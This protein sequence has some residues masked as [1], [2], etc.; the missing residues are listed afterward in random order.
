MV[1]S[2]RILSGLRSDHGERSM[3]VDGKSAGQRCFRRGPETEFVVCVGHGFQSKDNHVGL[4][5][6]I[7]SVGNRPSSAA[8][9]KRPARLVFPD[10]TSAPFVIA[11]AT[12]RDDAPQVAKYVEGPSTRGPSGAPVRSDG[13][14]ERRPEHRARAYLLLKCGG[15]I[16]HERHSDTIIMKPPVPQ[17]PFDRRSWKASHVRVCSHCAIRSVAN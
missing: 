14:I 2:P 15:P 11:W 4:R 6:R 1:C 9:C 3:P 12:V 17:I 8:S 10:V 5:L 13:L 16:Q 7:P